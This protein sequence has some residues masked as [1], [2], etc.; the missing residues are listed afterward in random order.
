MTGQILKVEF[1][2]DRGLK[3][4]GRLHLP[5]GQTLTYA[6]FAHCFTC[7]KDVH[8]AR[9][10]CQGLAERGIAALR[11]DFTAIGESQ[12]DFAD[13]NFTTMV[14]DLASAAEFLRQNYS[15]PE[16]I[17]GHSLGGTAS[18][19]AG[20]KI[21]GIKAVSTINSPCHP[22]HVAKHFKHVT[23]A[24]LWEGQADVELQGRTFTIRKHFLDDLESYDMDKVLYDY[25]GALLVFHAP[26]DDTVDIRNAN[27]IFSMAKHPK[28]FISLNKAD[29]LIRERRDADYIA[30]SIVAWS[31]RYI[32]FAPCVN[33]KPDVSGQVLVTETD[34]GL[35][36]QRVYIGDHTLRA[37]E[38]KSVPG[39]LDMGPSPYDYIL[40][41]LG[42]CTS[43]TIRMYAEHKGWKVDKTSVALAHKKIHAQDCQ[44]CDGQTGLI[45]EIDREIILEGD[46]TPEQRASIL[47]IANKCPVHKTLTQ[48]V[49]IRS[50]L[51]E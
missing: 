44:D 31:S 45:D 47:A 4:A 1:L 37:D 48:V 14:A 8:A 41:G 34:E 43:M 26:L 22:K 50:S 35:Y 39:G 25:H 20:T 23:Q 15:A 30:A 6:L 11:F 5:P 17:I 16:I 27:E 33:A 13:T 7:G 2:N 40:A 42:A 49:K 3:L 46:L 36:T 32:D 21:P 24:I 28:S 51:K 29:H 38:P 19:V 18:I 12:G 9:R 10:I